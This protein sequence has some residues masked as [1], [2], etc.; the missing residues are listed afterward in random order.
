MVASE[1]LKD[2]LRRELGGFKRLAILGIGNELRGDDGLGVVAT[3]RL[4]L[5]LGKLAHVDIIVAGNCP[6]NFTGRVGRL[7]PSHILLI[8]AVDWGEKRVR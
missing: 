6:E 7:S 4:K 2:K 1:C 8:D 5:A 3:R